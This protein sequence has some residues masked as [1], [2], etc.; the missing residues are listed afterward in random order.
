MHTSLIKALVFSVVFAVALPG[1]GNLPSSGFL[2]RSVESGN[3]QDQ[4]G[5]QFVEV[6]D[7]V[8]RQL[9]AQRTTRLFSETLGS[10]VPN[11]EIIRAGDVLDVTIW[12]APPSALFTGGVEVR[13]VA[14]SGAPRAT[15]F[16]DQMVNS[17]GNI[18][19]PFAGRIPVAGRLPRQVEDEIT[20]RLKGMAHQP[21][22]LVRRTH[23][24]S[25]DVTVVGEVARSARVPLT[26][27]G[28]TLLD[29]LAAAGGV[30]Q[31]VN[32]TTIQVTRGK[33]VQALP[34]DII[35]RDPNQNVP[36]QPGDVITALFQPLS[37][38]SLGAAGRNAEIDFEAQGISL[39]QALA[40]AGGTQD[41]RADARGVFIFRFEPREA[42]Q[43]PRQPVEVT[44]EG[45]VP[46]VYRLNLDDP[47]S[48]LVSQSFPI[49]NKDVLYISNASLAELQKFLNL[50]GSV[51]GPFA[52]FKVLTD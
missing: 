23:N 19:I 8:A 46:V 42:L 43:W 36:L 38:T 29:I 50:L 22:V 49:N 14:S 52:T 28:E 16:P 40:R 21:Q 48:F 20:G 39:A 32:K 51:I 12:E 7:Q 15:T 1:C 13:G 10:A 11:T 27:R 45:K 4:G 35:I 30:R 17:E 18:T 47:A 5:I 2:R 41:H 37:F 44:P 25:S 33:T 24:L 6:T 26:P 34:L 3:E 31:P 9:L